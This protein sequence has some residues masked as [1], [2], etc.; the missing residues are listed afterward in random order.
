MSDGFHAS[1]KLARASKRR[2]Q[3]LYQ[4]RPKNGIYVLWTRFAIA[5][6]AIGSPDLTAMR[7]TLPSAPLVRR[8]RVGLP[9]L[10]SI[11]ATFEA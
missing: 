5:N 3:K 4:F 1:E 8:T 9:D 11:S 10:G 7:C 6:Y 2:G